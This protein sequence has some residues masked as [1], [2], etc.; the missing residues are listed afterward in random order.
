MEQ[1]M[2]IELAG[3]ICQTRPLTVDEALELAAN[4]S[5]DR[6]CGLADDVRR[7]LCG[8]EIDTCSIVNARSGRC[9]ED[10]K[11]CAQSAHHHTGVTEYD[12]VPEAE[13]MATL[14]RNVA[15]GVKRFSL[16]TSGRRV[17]DVAPFCRLYELASR[18]APQMFLCASMGLLTPEQFR[19]LRKAGV[20]RYHCNLE[21][22]PEYFPNLCTTHTQEDKLRAIADARQA[23]LEVCSGGIIGMGESMRDRL[24]MVV[25]AVEAGAVSVPVNILMPVKGTPLEHQAPLPADEIVLTAALMRL[26]AGGVAIRFAGGRA[27]LDASTVERML[28]GGVN[29]ALVGDMLTTVGNNM[30]GDRQMFDR[31]RRDEQDSH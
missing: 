2:T 13:M 24:R 26:V 9:P 6:I 1:K 17:R 11:W 10:C 29:G 12:I 3:Q 28:R 27:L 23:G 7:R 8:S 14:R 31:V 4:E 18:E 21:S 15:Q 22:S 25:T 30:E 20:R 19:E 5:V 16:V